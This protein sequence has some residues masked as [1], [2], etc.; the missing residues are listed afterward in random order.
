MSEEA[1]SAL[2]GYLHLSRTGAGGVD[3]SGHGS[4]CGRMYRSSNASLGQRGDVGEPQSGVQSSWRTS[5]LVVGRRG[6]S[7]AT[8]AVRLSVGHMSPRPPPAE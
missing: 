4:T 5:G 8:K 2:L 7:S 1:L 6:W 3:A